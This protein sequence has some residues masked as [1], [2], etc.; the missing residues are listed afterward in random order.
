MRSK[1]ASFPGT[2][3]VF[4]EGTTQAGGPPMLEKMR[5]GSIDAAFESGK[6]V[7]PVRSAPALYG[8]PPLTAAPACRLPSS[9]ARPSGWVSGRR[10]TG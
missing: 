5:M 7:Q 3:L 9:I 8:C 2:I 10:P 1:I 6:L 4:P